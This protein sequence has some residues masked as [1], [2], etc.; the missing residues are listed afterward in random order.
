MK[1]ELRSVRLVAAWT[2]DAGDD[3]CGICRNPFDACCPECHLPGDSCPITWGVC[4]HPFHV[5]CIEKWVNAQPPDAQ[6]CPMCRQEWIVK[7]TPKPS[8][9][10]PTSPAAAPQPPAWTRGRSPNEDTDT[11]E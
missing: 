2:W 4:N 1:V 9:D 3:A 7:G 8:D 10:A 6:K 5:H 11:S